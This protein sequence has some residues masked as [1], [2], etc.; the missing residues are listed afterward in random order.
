MAKYVPDV[1]TQ[2]WVVISPV[3]TKRPD[4]ATAPAQAPASVCP[5]CAGNESLTPPEVY[6]IGEGEAD[7][8]GWLVRVVPNKFPITDIHEVFIHSTSHTDDVDKLPL[9][10]VTRIFT[11]YRDRYRAHEKDG[12][13]LI[14]CNHGYQA[15]ASLTHPHSQLVVLPKQINLDSLSREPINN[16]VEDNTLFVTYCPDF[17]QWPYEVWITPK[18]EGSMF[19]DT[20]D[21]ALGDLAYVLQRALRKI[22][23]V[24][25][26]SPIRPKDKANDPF[27]FNYYISQGQN[28]FLRIVPRFIHRAGFELGTGLNVNVIDPTE[29]AKELAGVK[30]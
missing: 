30:I 1:K 22:S 3:R 24:F 2:R 12:Q 13:I 5:F 7:K 29:A 18:A 14:F 25:G 20:D 16:I 28:W 4:S 6:R 8:P 27:V 17:S 10:Q 23:V 21:K 19:G 15:G 9:E 26:R 11:C